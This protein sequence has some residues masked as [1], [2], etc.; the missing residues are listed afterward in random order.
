VR[1]DEHF[2]KPTLLQL[3]RVAALTRR[4]VL[5]VALAWALAGIVPGSAAGQAATPAPGPSRPPTCA[6]RFPAEGPAGVD[7]RL[8]CIVSEI[9]GLYTASGPGDPPTLSAYVVTLA[10]LVAAGVL[11]AAVALRLLARR[12]SRRLAPVLPET[13]WVCPDC[14]SVNA[15]GVARC[16]RCGSPPGDGPVLPTTGRPETPQTLGRTGR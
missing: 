16:Y 1:G 9:V 13:W 8:G 3:W 11:L 14:H 15:A 10:V 6:E 2:R 7:L 5:G 12:A 4:I